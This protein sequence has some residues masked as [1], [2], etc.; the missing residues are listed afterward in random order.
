MKEILKTLLVIGVIPVLA[1]SILIFDGKSNMF[2][3]GVAL[4]APFPLVLFFLRTLINN[5]KNKFLA[6]INASGTPKYQLYRN[7]SGI[8]VTT[9]GKIILSTGARAKSYDFS[10]VRQWR[11]SLQAPGM[12]FGGGLNGAMV[13]MVEMNRAAQ[14]TGLFLL[15]KD[16][17][18]P[19]WHIKISDKKVLS[20][21]YEILHQELNEGT[22]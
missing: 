9:N 20:K 6:E 12:A 4:V 17:E 3:V 1:G 16:I 2:L 7:N 19:E 21:W 11:T 13:N 15:V 14:N 5:D 22:S 18:D 8:A 10:S